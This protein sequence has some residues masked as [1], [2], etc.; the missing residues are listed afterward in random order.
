M[1]PKSLNLF[2]GPGVGKTTLMAAVFAELKFR[3]LNVE[4]VPE[5]AKELAWQDNPVFN[6]YDIFNKQSTR[7]SVANKVDLVV[8]DGPL[9]MQLAY[10]ED[11]HEL[12]QCVIDEHNKYNNLNILVLRGDSAP[13]NTAGRYQDEATART[14]DEDIKNLLAG[15][16]CD[17][18]IVGFRRNAVDQIVSLLE[19]AGWIE[20]SANVR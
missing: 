8:T 6:Q 16:K 9:L 17:Y 12:A 19:M 2:A 7:M 3:N 10:L 1:K 4:M 18:H 11:Q 14:I 5:Y 20:G 15:Q 13:Y